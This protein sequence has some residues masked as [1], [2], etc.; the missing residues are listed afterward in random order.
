METKLTARQAFDAM[1]DFLETYYDQTYSKQINCLLSDMDM[2]T[3]GDGNETAD[4]ALW[5]DWLECING[6]D[7]LKPQEAYKAVARFV[8]MRYALQPDEYIVALI[9]GMRA[10]NND[11]LVNTLFWQQWLNAVKKELNS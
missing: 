11:F 1:T 3:W 8:S 4:P 10:L 5:D 7:N 6:N 9:K 2:S